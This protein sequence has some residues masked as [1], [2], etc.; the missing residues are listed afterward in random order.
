M[1]KYLLLIMFLY[2]LA[3]SQTNINPTQTPL[4]SSLNI[5]TVGSPLRGSQINSRKINNGINSI[6][7][8]LLEEFEDNTF[9][10]A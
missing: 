4:G 8:F 9:P 10:P 6:L 7:A 1:I 5:N 3:F 2:S